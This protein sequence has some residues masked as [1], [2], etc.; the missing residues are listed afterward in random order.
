MPDVSPSPPVVE[1]EEIIVIPAKLVGY[2]KDSLPFSMEE[3]RKIWVKGTI[4]PAE[5]MYVILQNLNGLELT[6]AASDNKTLNVKTLIRLETANTIYA[7]PYDVNT[8]EYRLGAAS[9]IEKQ[10]P[11]YSARTLLLMTPFRR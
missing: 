10:R 5:R 7:I 4:I 11:A 1:K 9:P 6:K 3:V 2:L 8:N